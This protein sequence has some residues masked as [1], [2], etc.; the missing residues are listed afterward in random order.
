MA[1]H[2]S[3]SKLQSPSAAN[4]KMI[5]AS[6]KRAA[7]RKLPVKL[8]GDC[9]PSPVEGLSEFSQRVGIVGDAAAERYV[10]HDRTPIRALGQRV[11][12]THEAV[13]VGAF[14][15]NAR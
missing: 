3:S 8:L 6:C 5:V 2:F 10:V 9:R 11:A 13:Y 7:S 4:S 12:T 15:I 14:D 1:R